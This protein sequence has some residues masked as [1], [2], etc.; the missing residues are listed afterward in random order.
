MRSNRSL[1][2]AFFALTFAL[3]W[4]IWVPVMTSSFGLPGFQFPPAGLVGAIMPGIAAVVVAALGGD[5]TGVGS[6]LRQVKVWRVAA[7]WYLIAVLLMPAL[8]GLVFAVS[9]F[10]RGA[11]LPAPEFS[12]GALLFMVLIQTPNTLLEE[13]GWRGFALPRMAQAQGWLAASLTLGVIWAAW[14]LPYWISAP[15]VHQYGPAAVVL[16]FVMP[17]SGSVFV[18]WMYRSTGS[19]LLSWLWHLT[20]NTAIAFLPL[21]SEA[22]G[23]L[24]PQT[25]YTA[26]IL[27][28]A[29]FAGVRLA[30]AEPTGKATRP[31]SRTPISASSAS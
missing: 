28:L 30:H 10:W 29:L 3:S 16:F 26:L 31:A 13:I 2:I 25:L 5:R 24:W 4:I 1:L 22:I 12:L 19:V 9:S 11:S 23:S 6:L 18:A 21:S 20:T 17:M 8:I 7:G 27:G 15:N 14:H